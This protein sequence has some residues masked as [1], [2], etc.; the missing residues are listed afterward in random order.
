M[1]GP[2]DPA[3]PMRL[4]VS[5]TDRHAVA[6]VLREAAGEGRLD[7]DEL[8][9]RLEATYAAK[10]YADLVPLLADLPGASP[11]PQAAPVVRRAGTPAYPGPIDHL[12]RHTS[13]LAIMGGQDRKGVWVVPPVHTAFT[14]MG[15]ID[16]DLR[17]AVFSSPEVVI[18]ANV[19][20]GGID[21]IVNARTRVQVEGIGIMGAFEEGR[22]KVD[23][24]IGPDSPLVRVRGMA[25]MGAVTVVR[26]PMPGQGRKRLGRAPS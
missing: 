10:V 20:M 14:L 16:V 15:G 23:P 19:V 6:E 24:E 17:E 3:D 7:V 11:L 22:A 8:E 13:S 18:N 26:K 1:E 25:L 12:P 2:L 21:I 9:E 4:R 5:D